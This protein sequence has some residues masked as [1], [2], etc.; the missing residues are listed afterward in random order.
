MT[1]KG[2]LGLFPE[3]GDQPRPALQRLQSAGGIATHFVDGVQAQIGQFALL[4]VAKQVFDGIQFGCVG[5]KSL[6]HDAI[7]ERLDIGAHQPAAMRRQAVPDDQQLALDLPRQRLQV[8]D[9]LRRLDRAMEEAEVEIR[10]RH[11]G[12][13]R[14]LLPVEAVWQDRGLALRRPSLYP[15]GA[16]AQSRLVDEDDRAALAPA[17]FLAPASA[18]SSKRGSPPRRAGWHG[19]SDA[20][21]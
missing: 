21:W 7:A 10:H 19:P 6:Q 12:D 14:Q 20:G 11:P 1:S 8:L 5:R 2:Q 13:Q 9:Q 15:R 16:L 18:A 4:G 17:L 3:C